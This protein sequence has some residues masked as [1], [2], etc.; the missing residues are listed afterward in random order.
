MAKNQFRKK[1]VRKITPNGLYSMRL[2]NFEVYLTEKEEVSGLSSELQ[3][4]VASTGELLYQNPNDGLQGFYKKGKQPRAWVL[5]TE[6]SEK[7]IVRLTRG[8]FDSLKIIEKDSNDKP[9]SPDSMG[10]NGF[11]SI[12]KNKLKDLA[13]TTPAIRDAHEAFLLAAREY[14]L[15]LYAEINI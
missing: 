15:A 10:Y 12:S 2:K 13:E 7:E 3:S 5:V 1:A 14:M 9:I 11:D 8:S 6:P 4:V